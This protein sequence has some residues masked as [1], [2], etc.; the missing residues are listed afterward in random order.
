MV[1]DY[2]KRGTLKLL[3]QILIQLN[4]AKSNCP[5]DIGGFKFG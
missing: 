5:I 3:N 2:T 1:H 4:H